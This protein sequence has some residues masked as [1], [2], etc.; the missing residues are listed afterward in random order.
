MEKVWKINKFF[1]TVSIP[2]NHLQADLRLNGTGKLPY[3]FNQ[4]F[5]PGKGN[6]FIEKKMVLA[7]RPDDR[8][9]G[10]RSCLASMEP[11]PTYLLSINT[12]LLTELI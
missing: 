10:R 3:L 5:W 6:V 9:G 7:L 2:Q 12:K 8:L 11:R 4:V 1:T